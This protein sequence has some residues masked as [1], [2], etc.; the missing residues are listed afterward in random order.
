MRLMNSDTSPSAD[1]FTGNPTADD[2]DFAR[3]FRHFVDRMVNLAGDDGA[4]QTPLG[5]LVSE[6]LQVDASALSAVEESIA[7]HRLAD[8][9]A[10]LEA[11]ADTSQLLG[12]GGGRQKN[13]EN[14]VDLIT[15]AHIRFGVGPV[16]YQAV[17]VAYG[18]QI[19]AVAFGLR[20]IT[21]DGVRFAVLQR[22]ADPVNGQNL[23]RIEV[24][25]EKPTAASAFIDR[26][27]VEMDAHSVLRGQ[28]LAYT[29]A[30]ADYGVASA[31]FLPR[32]SVPANAIV[33][34]EGTLA[35]VREHVLGVREHADRLRELGAH[36]KRGVLLYGPPG[37]GKTLT[38]SHLLS[39]AHGVTSIVLTGQSIRFITEAARLARSLQPS[40]VV[41]E[42]VDLVAEDR[43]IHDGSQPLL[44]AVLDALEGLDG[45]ADIAFILTT[46][47]VAVLE[48][49]LVQRPGRV[50]LAIELP[51][52]GV[53]ERRRLFAHFASG[54]P[55]SA[56][57][58]TAAA[59][60]AQGVTG[61]FARELVRRAL[62]RAVIDEREPI[63]SDLED[64]LT[65]L[66]DESETLS[67]R[68]ISGEFENS[69]F[70]EEL[71]DLEVD[72]EGDT[73]GS[74]L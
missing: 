63:D 44:F 35:R 54:T 61:S 67:A 6:H 20:L 47:R 64:A 40:I 46:N 29:V 2:R 62:L 50:D 30:D 65:A 53:E 17:D 5:L 70:L 66:L 15:S 48:E 14:F 51:R 3:S 71:D 37:T 73:P 68:M 36:L 49:A 41:L 72:S 12:V 25:T 34:P 56:Q 4:V 39:E 32:P 52:P 11:L 31:K 60:R 26:L 57:A 24:L 58:V 21:V 22:A 10:A 9:D 59:D 43:D 28:V 7:G 45:D 23:G 19:S 42:D 13:F 74:R 18:R 27:R 1:D 69:A 33:L 55:F 16:D 8:L 38:V